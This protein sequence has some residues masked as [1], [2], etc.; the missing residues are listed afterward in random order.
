VLAFFAASDGI[1]LENLAQ[2]FMS[3]I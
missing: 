2:R 3:E 1:V